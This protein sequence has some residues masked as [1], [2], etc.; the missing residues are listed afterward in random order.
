[1]STEDTGVILCGIPQPNPEYPQPTKT[2]KKCEAD[3]CPKCGGHC[4]AG[5]GLAY[6][7]VGSYVACN[8]CDYYFK[9]QDK[10][11]QNEVQDKVPQA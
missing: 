10:G 1:M 8:D 4:S 3:I 2:C 9:Q 6:G 7:G 5:Y 11:E